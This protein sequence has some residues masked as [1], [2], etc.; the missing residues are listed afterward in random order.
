NLT[1]K[2]YQEQRLR[3]NLP[4]AINPWAEPQITSH[5]NRSLLLI[6]SR[7]PLDA[8]IGSAAT[9]WWEG[10]P[11]LCVSHRAEGE[12][13]GK[14]EKSKFQSDHAQRPLCTRESLY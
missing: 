1:E 11:G 4:R 6:A 7:R 10:S 9:R 14:T 5:R 12:S 8:Q 2:R 3:L 13:D